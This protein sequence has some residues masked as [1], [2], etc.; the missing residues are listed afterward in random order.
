MRVLM[1]HN[2]YLLPGGEDISTRMEADLLRD[3]GCSV[4]LCEEHNE[5]VAEIGVVNAAARTIWSTESY[6]RI[7]A[8]LR[9]A[10]YDIVHV[11]NFF[12]L[13][14]PAAY[15][16]AR[17]E[18]VPVVQSLRNY[19]LLCP[20]G[21][22]L[23]QGRVCEDCLGK[24]VALPGILHACY[25]GSRAATATIAAMITT[26]RVLG[27]WH[28]LVDAYIA[29]SDFGRRKF[30]QG[31]FPIDKFH[32]K[33][34]FVYP[35]P[36]NADGSG[37]YALFV[38][39][40]D[41]QKGIETLLSAWEIVGNLGVLKLAGDGPLSESVRTVAARIPTIE[42]L[43]RTTIPETYD[44]MGRAAF[45]IFPPVTYESFGRVA[46]EAFAKGTPVIASDIGPM[47]E[48]VDDGITGLLF[49]AGDASTLAALA[50]WAFGHAR[51]MS[52]MRAHARARYEA[53]FT[54]ERNLRLLL[55]IYEAAIDGRRAKPR[56]RGWRTGQNHA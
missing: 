16:A 56:P 40:F 42:W 29:L 37:G 32:V 54:S 28:H 24:P 5:R 18:G 23:R 12:P 30:A 36:G 19:R 38:G 44:L 49:P 46:I 1:L 55:D 17:A 50:I 27:T 31:G 2:A 8:Q 45:V 52:A 34:N 39:R 48:L 20:G 53:R 22:F 11:Q 41:R 7:R 43:G 25:R 47:S 13:I 33:P 26:H 51:E 3:A 4:A 35:D 14:S 6:A 10:R 21:S 15:Y 9:G